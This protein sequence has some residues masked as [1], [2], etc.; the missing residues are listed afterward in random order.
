M[1][2][3][4]HVADALRL[5][6]LRRPVHAGATLSAAQIVG[7][8]A[9]LAFLDI[10]VEQRIGGPESAFQIYGVNSTIAFLAAQFGLVA[11]FARIDRSGATLRNLL[12]A[13]AALYLTLEAASLWSP[14]DRVHTPE[15]GLA[16]TIYSWLPIV[17]AIWAAAVAWRLFGGV[18]GCRWPGP[19]GVSFGGAL[20]ALFLLFP[21]MP[22]WLPENVDV[23]QVNVWEAVRAK[24][25]AAPAQKT[26]R[27]DSGARDEYFRAEATSAAL[28]LDQ[29]ARMDKALAALQPR[30]GKVANV[31]A[32]GLSG[33]DSETVFAG[34]ARKSLDI[35]AE[36]LGAKGHTLALVNGDAQD[37]PMASLVNLSAALRG[38]A[39][40]MDKENDLLVLAMTSHGS[41]QGFHLSQR[42]MYRRTLDPATL[43]RLLDEAGIRNRAVI[44]SACHS[45]VFVPALAEPRTAV[46]TAASAERASFG[47]SNDRDWTYFGEAFFDRSLRSESSLVATFEKARNLVGEWEARDNFTPS[48]PQIAVGEDFARR[49][50][51][52]A[53]SG[54]TQQAAPQKRLK[55]ATAQR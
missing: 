17:A 51:A 35:L 54:A 11:L 33:T 23:A 10:V 43:R 14:F 5:A 42:Q 37:A 48:Q 7:I 16:V 18:E 38:I 8:G 9:V 34:E 30:R 53:R 6:T 25:D 4:Q 2:F 24:H 15:P 27:D 45:G 47:C 20:F 55:A 3:I 31:W 29:P 13:V 12:L 39:A 19:R 40:R 28:E 36:R 21:H 41:T 50:P 32:I 52:L 44:V 49:F 46:F 22:V 1:M 26:G